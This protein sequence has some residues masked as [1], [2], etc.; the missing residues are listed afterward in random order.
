M[1][2]PESTE[3]EEYRYLD[4]ESVLDLLKTNPDLVMARLAEVLLAAPS[5]TEVTIIPDRVSVTFVHRDAGEAWQIMKTMRAILDKRPVRSPE[6]IAAD[7]G[8]GG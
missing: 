1:I 4:G 6:A 3:S 2:T 8:G 5:V 7:P